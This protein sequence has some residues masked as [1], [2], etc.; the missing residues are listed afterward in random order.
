MS[1]MW[2]GKDDESEGYFT[3][4]LYPLPGNPLEMEN[5]K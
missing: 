2:Q 5:P 4:L 1:A 3:W